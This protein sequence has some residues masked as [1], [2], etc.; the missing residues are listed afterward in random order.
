METDRHGHRGPHPDDPAHRTPTARRAV[1][2]VRRHAARAHRRP[3]DPPPRHP[4]PHR[5][6]R[7]PAPLRQRLPQRRGRPLPRRHRHRASATATSSRSCRPSPAA[8]AVADALRLA[9]RLGRRHAARRP[10][11][12]VAVARRAAVGQARG[13]QPDRLDQGPRRRC[14]MVEAAEKDGLLRPGCTI[15]EPTSGNTGISLAMAARLKGYRL[16]CVMPENTSVERTPAAARCGAPRS[17]PRRRPAARTR[18]SASPSG[19]PTEHPDWVMLYQYGNPANAR[20]ALRRHRPGDPRGPADHHPLRRR[21]RHHRHADGHRPLPARAGAGHRDRRRRAALR[22]ARLR[23]A[24]HRRG[25]RP[26]ALRRDRC[27]P[28][29]SRSARATRCAAPASCSRRRASSP[30][31]RPARSCTPRSAS[32]ARVVKAGGSADIAF[33]VCD[34]GWKYLSTG[35]Y[36]GTL[37]DAED[38]LDGQLWA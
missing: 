7:R 27:S 17:S 29:A 30:A 19:S 3:R 38:A 26:R 34:G 12:A 13:P 10:A 9:A 22:R 36:E 25:L 24:Q 20:R 31:S 4:R 11:A 28:R 16:V 1:E 32:P 6:R 37:D 15:L 35:A 18:P 33:V 23:P 8:D 2:G 5:R 21:P 14:A